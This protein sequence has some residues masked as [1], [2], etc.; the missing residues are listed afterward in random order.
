VKETQQVL[1]ATLGGANDKRISTAGKT[2]QLKDLSDAV[3]ALIDNVLAAVGETQKVVQG[4]LDGD[5]T[6]RISIE[7]K[8]GHFHA[9]S[10]AV[11]SLIENIMG[12]VRDV[13]IAAGEVFGSSTEI[14]RGNMDLSQRT[15]QQATVLEETASSMEE[16][17]TTVKKNADNAAQARTLAVAARTQA[18]KG[19]TVVSEAVVAMQSINAASK[20]IADIIGVIDEIAFQTNLLALNAAVEA[21][22]AG[23]QGRGFAVVATEVRSLASRSAAAAKEIK[24]LIHDSVDKVGQGTKLVD[25][26]GQ[27]LTEIVGSVKKVSDIVSEIATA[28]GEQ[29]SGIEQVNK[30]VTSMD[31]GTQQNAA[32]VEQAT[33]AAESLV[34]QAKQLDAMMDKYRV[35]GQNPLGRTVPSSAPHAVN[36]GMEPRRE[37][38]RPW[39]KTKATASRPMQKALQP[40]RQVAAAGTNG[41][42]EWNDF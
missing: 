19:G 4:A 11:N 10:V 29:A 17:T 31:E 39:S 16:M 8:T 28:S 40:K 33:A 18:E 25:A 6:S 23:D 35:D 32:L 15:E 21:A 22:R 26:S 27:T 30:A 3:N 24:T 2:G 36:A 12:V 42:E 37:A 13:K 41:G 5:L 9:L 1:Q 20:K 7:G 34:G 14:S 38:N